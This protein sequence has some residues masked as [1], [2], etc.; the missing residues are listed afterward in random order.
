M[1]MT[2]SSEQ[3][4]HVRSK[5]IP[6]VEGSYLDYHPRFLGRVD[7]VTFLG[8]LE[9]LANGVP[10]HVSTLREQRENW[11]KILQ[12]C[13]RYFRRSSPY[14]RIY[15]TALHLNPSYCGSLEMYL[16]ERAYGGAYSYYGRGERLAHVAQRHGYRTIYERDMTYHYY[17]SSVL[18]KNHFGNPAKLSLERALVT[19]PGALFI[20]PQLL[21]IVLYGHYGIWMW[22]FDGK[23][24]TYGGSPLTFDSNQDTR[25]TTLWWSVLQLD[26]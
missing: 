24:H 17:L 10:C 9:H 26:G 22:Q 11:G 19:V 12:N 20:N 23:V 25:P 1:G 13:R 5:G 2:I 4:K 14:K 16:L 18:D 6:C 8:S 3:A 7:V 15:T 21:N